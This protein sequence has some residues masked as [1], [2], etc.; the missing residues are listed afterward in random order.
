MGF[1]GPRRLHERPHLASNATCRD[2][3]VGVSSVDEVG[4]RA[5][6]WLYQTREQHIRREKAT[7]NICTAQVLLAVMARCMPPTTAPWARAIATVVHPR[8]RSCRCPP[9]RRRRGGGRALLRHPDRA[10]AWPR[11]RRRRC[12]TEEGSTCGAR[13]RTTVLISVD[14]T[15]DEADLAAV[16]TAFGVNRPVVTLAAPRGTPIC[17]RTTRVPHPPGLQQ[18]PQ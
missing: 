2:A 10:R 8:H 12:G 14:E 1:G 3:F 9:G 4:A 6:D 16:A 18:P 15:T 7:S 13:T 5:I 11:G 17:R